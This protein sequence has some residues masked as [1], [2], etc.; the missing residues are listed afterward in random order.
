[1]ERTQT[2]PAPSTQAPAARLLVADD[3]PAQMRA[4]CDTLGH[5][6]YDVIGVDSGPAA[7]E[8]LAGGGFDLLLTDLLMPGMDGIELLQ[9]ALA[10]DPSLVVVLT[11]GEG[12]IA[13]AV[14]AMRAGALDYVLKPFKLSA[15]LP[16]LSRA[17]AVRGLRLENAALERRLLQRNAELEAANEELRAFSYSVSHDLRAPLRAV[18]GFSR[19]L[20]EDHAAELTPPARR[21][22]DKVVGGATRMSQLIEDLLRFSQLGRQP[23]TKRPVEMGSLFGG[24]VDELRALHPERAVA[25]QVGELPGCEGDPALLRQVVVNLL[26]NA[27]KFTRGRAAAAIEIGGRV[28][29]GA[30]VYT[31]RDNGAGF[32]RARAQRLFGVFQRFHTDK[33]FEGTG[34]GLSIARLIVQRHGGRIGAESEE[35]QGA[36]FW[37][38]LPA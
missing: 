20:V 21:L 36:T 25:V 19:I 2:D 14:E 9:T 30:A 23:L 17:L 1:M 10:R 8:A 11:T 15:I 6:G 33:E 4:L 28:E 38:S 27:F 26:G 3:E 18:E 7:L 29:D 32:D 37:F 5:H 35:G 16:V 24:V 22:V 31:V 12:T 13:S 34:V